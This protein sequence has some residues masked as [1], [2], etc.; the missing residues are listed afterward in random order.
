MTANKPPY[1]PTEIPS[2]VADALGALAVDGCIS[3]ERARAFAAEQGLELRFVGYALD[4]LGLR[5][6]DCGL[7]CF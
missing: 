6:T 2:S 1:P 7:G 5:I 3:C 4:E